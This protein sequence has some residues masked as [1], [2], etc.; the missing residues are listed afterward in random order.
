MIWHDMIW[1]II[2]V[3]YLVPGITFVFSP[4]TYK[5]ARYIAPPA[6]ADGQRATVGMLARN[7]KLIQQAV[8]IAPSGP[9]YR[10]LLILLQKS[11][12]SLLPIAWNS[13]GTCATDSPVFSF[14]CGC[15]PS[16]LVHPSSLP[17][18]TDDEAACKN[19]ERIICTKKLTR[20]RYDSSIMPCTRSCTR[21][22]VSYFLL[23]HITRSCWYSIYRIYDLHYQYMMSYDMHVIF[24]L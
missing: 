8:L 18:T 16:T 4:P 24:T 9:D 19:R 13:S 15:D 10:L 6:S 17:T 7:G 20:T 22:L 5:P 21:Y 23:G 12:N 14:S 1:W 2:R 11:I 3:W